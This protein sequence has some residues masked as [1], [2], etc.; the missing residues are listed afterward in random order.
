MDYMAL[1][2]IEVDTGEEQKSISMQTV[3][4]TTAVYM[5][6]EILKEAT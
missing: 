6:M 5:I 2:K 1:N 4:S 3:D